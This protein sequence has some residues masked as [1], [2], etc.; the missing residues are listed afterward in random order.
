MAVAAPL[1]RPAPAV[2][3]APARKSAS[4]PTHAAAAAAPAAS[5]AGH[6][7]GPALKLVAATEKDPRFKKAIDRL[8]YNAHKEKQHPP[9]KK[10]ADAA[11]AAA[12]APPNEQLAGAQANKVNAMQEAKPGKKPEPKS[13]LEML[14]AEIQKVMPKKTEDAGDFMK[15]DDRQ[16][17]K[18]AMTGNVQEQKSKTSEAI[19]SANRAPVD[20]NSV[21]EQKDTPL[22]SLPAPAMPPPI[23]AAGAMPERRPESDVTLQPAKQDTDRLLTDADVTPRQL[24][25]ANDPR[26]SAV[27]TA[28]SAADRYADTAPKGFRATEQNVLVTAAAKATADEHHGLAG[29]Q[30]VK[31]HTGK[32]VRDT[33][34]RPRRRT[35]PRGRRSSPTSRRCSRRPKKTFDD[36]LTSLDTD[37]T[38]TFDAGADAAVQKMRDYVDVRFKDRY[39]GWGGK[40]LK[41]KD[42]AFPLPHKVKVWFDEAYEVFQQELD[43][44]VLRVANLV[45]TRLKEAHDEIERGQ[46]EIHTYVEGLKG[47]LKSVGTAAEKD[48]QGRFQEL[49]QGVD[50]KRSDL[51]EKLAQR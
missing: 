20:P 5:H 42:W 19:D 47:S 43:A 1:S 26:F 8:N 37:V 18:S 50:D 49:S 3:K 36:K 34:S 28:K 22:P 31:G 21:P 40:A 41:L 25:K 46:R 6:H 48:V 15:G 24:Q 16:Q 33:S 45:E 11:E 35:R 4:T 27:L 39:S 13:F 2:A 17:L 32:S 29:M 30:A 9:S 14:R 7:G 12:K 44:L 51:A 10:E 23:G 38:A